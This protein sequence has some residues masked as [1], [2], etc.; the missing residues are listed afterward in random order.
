MSRSGTRDA[1][2]GLRRTG[3]LW[4]LADQSIS[5]V[6]NFA[7]AVLAGRRL[8][9]GDLGIV[10]I[11][12]SAYVI[13]L[14]FFRALVTDPAIVF[15]SARV[16]DRDLSVRSSITVTLAAGSGIALTLGLLGL[17]LN[18]IVWQGLWLFAPWMVPALLQ[19]YWRFALFSSGRRGSAVLNDGL[20]MVVMFLTL[21]FAWRSG[22]PW[23]IVSAWGLGATFA[24]LLGFI[25][26][27]AIPGR[28]GVSVKW[29]RREAIRLGRWLALE[30]AFLALGSQGAVFL[31]ALFLSAD[32]LGGLRA[33]QSIF[34]P[35]TLIAPAIALPGLPALTLALRHSPEHA[36][37]LAR[38]LS[39]AAC[40][41]TGLYVAA[42]LIA[43]GRLLGLVYG[44]GFSKFADLVVPVAIG[45]AAHAAAAGY[46]LLLKATSHG[47]ILATARGAG[48]AIALGL[49]G[50]LAGRIGV[51][52]AA[53]GL[54]CGVVV[55]TTLI[56]VGSRRIKI[57][58]VLA[59]SAVSSTVSLTPPGAVD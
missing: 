5:S 19:D 42:F 25:Q 48:A 29:W 15:G 40:G 39:F 3:I 41:L 17:M 1:S 27:R 33:V 16:K 38:R 10:S 24:S 52:A 18:G 21:P 47:R 31:L 20:W 59:G 8:G 53:W 50:F 49:A 32:A 26:M 2:P 45:Q 6:T 13:A 14:V 30:T 34:A 23:A 4:G 51:V 36:R 54:T 11:G 7:L 35:I 57:A 55:S 22:E 28:L 37:A 56:M 12:F 43:P 9:P 44:R 46:I 58:G